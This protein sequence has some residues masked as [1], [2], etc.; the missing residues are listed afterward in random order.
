M[1]G[2]ERLSWRKKISKRLEARDRLEWHCFKDVIR[3]HNKLFESADTSKSRLVQLEIQVVQLQQE[4]L[5]LQGRVQELSLTGGGAGGGAGSEKIALLEQ[6][7]FKLQ[8]EVTELHRQRGENAQK[9]LD[10]NNA[11]RQKEQELQTKEGQFEDLTINK[12]DLDKECTRLQQTIIELD[13]TCQLVKDELQALQLAY[14]ALEEKNRKTIEE[15]QELI[16]RWMTEKAKAANEVNAQN[17]MQ[18][19]IRQQKLQKELLEASKE[20]VKEPSYNFEGPAAVPF[21]AIVSVPSYPERKFDAHDGEVN[22]ARFSTSGRFFATGGADRKVKIWEQVNGNYVSKCIIHGSNAGIM[23]VQFDPQEKLILAASHEGACR[24]WTFADQRL[25][26]T[27]TGHSQKVMTA[28]FFGAATKVVSGG[29]DR[30]LKIW[31]L[32]SRQCTRTIFAGSSCN[33]IVINEGIGS[34]V[35]SGHLDKT[36]RFWDIRTENQSPVGEITLQGKITSL[37]LTL[38][39]NYMLASARDDTVKLLDLRMNQVISTCFADGFKVAM[40]YT[41]ASFSP[42]GQYVIC[43]SHDGSIFVWNASSAK[44]EKVLK[45]HTS[46]VV[47]CA[48]HPDGSSI[49]SCD[50]NKRAIIWT[51]RY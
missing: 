4:K 17:E 31:D 11:L 41:R 22:A 44:L 2:G 47:V 29:H 28:K 34:Q 20:P 40:D 25:R 10:V 32:R 26:H 27:L 5:E 24:V 45:E 14:S 38:D 43:G 18:L 51:N 21:C 16:T 7:L 36:V 1:A 33:D 12:Q 30:T 13:A 42:D 19:R 35:A 8:E 50:R 39:L 6:K 46:S 48:W 37:D 9:L 49:I 15:N 3:E 23:S